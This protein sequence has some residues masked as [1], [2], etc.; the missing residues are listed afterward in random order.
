MGVT[1]K[2]QPSAN[3]ELARQIIKLFETRDMQATVSPGVKFRS[4]STVNVQPA[5]PDA[6]T[7]PATTRGPLWGYLKSQ[8]LIDLVKFWR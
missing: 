3:A 2:F 5:R 6:M 1:G 7:E 4:D 8:V